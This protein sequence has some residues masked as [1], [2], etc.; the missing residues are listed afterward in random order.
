[1][2]SVTIPTEGTTLTYLQIANEIFQKACGW[3]LKLPTK[4]LW[5]VSGL[6][7]VFKLIN[8]KMFSVNPFCW[9]DEI[10]STPFPSL[11]EGS[12]FFAVRESFQFR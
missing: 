9:R 2:Y 11:A 5:V 10:L 1:M 6:Q 3:S 4:V 12:S 7:G 8:S